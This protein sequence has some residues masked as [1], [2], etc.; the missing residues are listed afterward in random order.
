[1][2]QV[3]GREEEWFDFVWNRTRGIRKVKGCSN[4]NVNFNF[5]YYSYNYIL[6]KKIYTLQII[7]IIKSD[8]VENHDY[9]NSVN[10][11]VVWAGH[12]YIPHLNTVLVAVRH[13]N[14]R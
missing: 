9:D 14:R 12:I 7:L 4:Y 2:D 10:P 11:Q 6:Q 5:I 3:E 13:R 8:W 1:M